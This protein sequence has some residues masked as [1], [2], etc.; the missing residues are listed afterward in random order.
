MNYEIVWEYK[1]P[2]IFFCIIMEQSYILGGKI[3]V[4]YIK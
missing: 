2:T 1:K 3:G 4:V